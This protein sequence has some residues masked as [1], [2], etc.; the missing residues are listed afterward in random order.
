MTHAQ[1]FSLREFYFLEETVPNAAIL[2]FKKEII[3]LCEAFGRSGQSGGSAP[4][5]A[6]AISDAINKLLLFNP[7]SPVTGSDNEWMECNER[8]SQNSR[9]SA[10]FKNKYGRCHYLD[11]IIWKGEEEYDT[12]TGRV[13]IDEKDFE[14]ISSKQFVKLPF[15]PK[16]FY[17]DVRRVPISK[18]EA[19]SKNMRF[20]E[21]SSKN[22]YYTVVKDPKQLEAVFEYY[23]KQNQP[24]QG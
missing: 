22:C 14:I 12:F 19:E 3:A 16:T 21:D 15:T 11:A 10:L 1:S 20:V 17:V 9:C 2:P 24:E 4:Y 23:V 7:I 5:L 6:G 18:E 13:Y 8:V